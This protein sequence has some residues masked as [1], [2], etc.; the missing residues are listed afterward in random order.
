MVVDDGDNE[1]DDSDLP[2]VNEAHV[3]RE[4]PAD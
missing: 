2:A 1:G 4:N 3:E